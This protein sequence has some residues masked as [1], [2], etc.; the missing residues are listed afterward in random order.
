MTSRSIV[1]AGGGL[2]AQRA[3]E[4]LRRHGFDGPLCLLAAE[5]EAPYDRPPLS[6]A[7]LAGEVGERAL[8][9]RDDDWYADNAIDVVLGDPVAGLDAIERAVVLKSGR[10]VSFG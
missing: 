5:A 9:F 1:I 8:R 3:A 7:F 6:K 2:A 10:R 4:T